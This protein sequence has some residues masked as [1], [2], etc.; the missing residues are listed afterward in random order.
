[1]EVLFVMKGTLPALAL[2]ILE[3]EFNAFCNAAELL[4]ADDKLYDIAYL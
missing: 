1:V 2:E 4:V 3:I